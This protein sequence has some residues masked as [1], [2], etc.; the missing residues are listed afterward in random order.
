MIVIKSYDDERN[1]RYY[2][3]CK[4]NANKR[5]WIKIWKYS[6]SQLRNGGSSVI[7][8][9]ASGE[10]VTHVEE[11]KNGEDREKEGKSLVWVTNTLTGNEHGNK[12]S[13]W[14]A[15]ELQKEKYNGSRKEE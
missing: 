10:A 1:N 3:R 15:R 4:S 9:R 12:N 13:L 5:D 7:N 8:L 2:E 14:G 6:R 11:N